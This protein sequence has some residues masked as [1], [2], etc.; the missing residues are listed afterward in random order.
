MKQTVSILTGLVVVVLLATGL[1]VADSIDLSRRLEQQA[2]DL[3]AWQAKLDESQK[4]LKKTAAERD[5]LS[6]QL[7][8]AVLASQT[9]YENAEEQ[10]RLNDAARLELEELKV[11]Y[12]DLTKAC[13]A[14]EAQVSAMHQPYLLKEAPQPTSA[15]A[16]PI[17]R[18]ERYVKN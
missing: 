2:N 1:I 9:A 10:S 7:N 6:A 11:E 17:R 13:D 5:A 8:E 3:L 15:P 4:L 16:V 18:P 14:L 12:L